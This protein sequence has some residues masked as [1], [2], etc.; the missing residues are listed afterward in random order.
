M[1]DLFA[2]LR[3]GTKVGSEV[4]IGDFVEVKNS[5]IDDGTKVAHLTYI[6]DC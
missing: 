5:T 1:S 3:P 6:G 2:Y 4:K